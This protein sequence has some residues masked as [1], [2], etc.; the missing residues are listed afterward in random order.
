MSP[1]NF[2]PPRIPGKDVRSVQDDELTAV[3]PYDAET[4]PSRQGEHRVERAQHE[5]AA[6]GLVQMLPGSLRS[7][8]D[9]YRRAEVDTPVGSV[10]DSAGSYAVVR[11]KLDQAVVDGDLEVAQ[12]LAVEA[13][14]AADQLAHHV[15]SNP[16]SRIR[17]AF[18]RRPRDEAGNLL[19]PGQSAR[20]AAATADVRK[21][22]QVGEARF[23]ESITWA[24]A[25]VTD[26]GQ[27][28][29]LQQRLFHAKMDFL[30]YRVGRGLIAVGDI[31]VTVDLHLTVRTAPDKLGTRGRDIRIPDDVTTVHYYEQP[32][33][34]FGQPYANAGYGGHG[35]GD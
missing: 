30:S 2:V 15:A 8:D 26:T 29:E 22:E 23:R 18:D 11:H 31:D 21:I 1:D 14:H 35:K 28:W 17:P 24:D 32:E 27:L 6:T 10:L 34:R 16:T 19:K 20:P 12:Q 4:R 25:T 5:S 9:A 3:V 13:V 33:Q 7:Y